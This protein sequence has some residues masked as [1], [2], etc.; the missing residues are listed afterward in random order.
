MKHWEATKN[1]D[2]K[3]ERK[4]R[5]GESMNLKWGRADLINKTKSVSFKRP[6]NYVTTWRV[7]AEKEKW[8]YFFHIR[9]ERK[10]AI[11]M[12]I[13]IK[14]KYNVHCQKAYISMKSMILQDV[15]WYKKDFQ[16]K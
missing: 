4:I 5:W 6:I 2:K 1:S 16:T 3:I 13:F 10:Y 7:W 8:K 11:S 15:N 9:N 14:Y 12:K